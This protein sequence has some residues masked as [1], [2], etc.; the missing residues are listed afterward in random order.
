MAWMDFMKWFLEV[1]C[2]IYGD[3]PKSIGENWGVFR[4][5]THQESVPSGLIEKGYGKEVYIGLDDGLG[6][7]GGCMVANV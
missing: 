6:D 3:C 4:E 5:I 1:L 2:Q 7:G